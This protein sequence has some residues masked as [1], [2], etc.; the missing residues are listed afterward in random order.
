MASDLQMAVDCNAAGSSAISVAS[1]VFEDR[2]TDLTAGTSASWGGIPVAPVGFTWTGPAP[3]RPTL[4]YSSYP[5]VG[6]APDWSIWCGG[7]S[8]TATAN[9]LAASGNGNWTHVNYPFTIGHTYLIQFQFVLVVV[10]E[11]FNAP[12][13]GTTSSASVTVAN[14]PDYAQAASPVTIW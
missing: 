14:P 8:G 3:P 4:N 12:G 1:V 11:V 5:T 6:V 10:A 7:T 2:I 13:G 9:S